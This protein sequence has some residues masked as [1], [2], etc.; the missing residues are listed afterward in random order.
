MGVCSQLGR[1]VISFCLPAGPTSAVRIIG[2]SSSGG[3]WDVKSAREG[4]ALRRSRKVVG[5]R[6]VVEVGGVGS[7]GSETAVAKVREGYRDGRRV[8]AGG[9]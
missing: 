4:P 2:S 1:R 3:R 7:V 6:C 5:G 9:A 8:D